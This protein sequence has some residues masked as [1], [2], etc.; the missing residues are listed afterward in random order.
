MFLVGLLAIL[1]LAV[2]NASPLAF[3][4][5]I[6]LGNIGVHLS[7]LAVLPGA[8][9]LKFFNHNVVQGPTVPVKSVGK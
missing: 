3:F 6:F 5:M 1:L 9:A 8:I 2:I 4:A 7:F